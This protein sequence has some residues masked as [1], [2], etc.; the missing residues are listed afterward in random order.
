MRS[1]QQWEVDQHFVR[2]RPGH[3]SY[4]FATNRIGEIEDWGTVLS[5]S[6]PSTWPKRNGSISRTSS[7]C[8]PTRGAYM[9]RCSRRH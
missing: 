9:A 6:F 3:P 5:M 2:T 4:D 8:S 1:G 7:R